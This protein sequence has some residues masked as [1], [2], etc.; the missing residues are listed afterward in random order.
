MC[1][2][3][4][5]E[6]KLL[7]EGASGDDAVPGDE[8]LSEEED[9]G[10]EVDALNAQ[11]QAGSGANAVMQQQLAACLA[12]TSVI[13]GLK[14]KIKEL[15]GKLAIRTRQLTAAEQ[16]NITLHGVEIDNAKLEE[17]VELKNEVI[18]GLKLELAT[19]RRKVVSYAKATLG[20][21]VLCVCV[22]VRVCVCVCVR[23][24]VCVWVCVCML[25]ML[26]VRSPAAAEDEAT[27]EGACGKGG[28]G[29]KGGKSGKGSKGSTKGSSSKTATAAASAS[30]AT[31]AK[32]SGR[33]SLQNCVNWACELL[34]HTPRSTLAV[35]CGTVCVCAC[36]CA[37]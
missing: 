19:L 32:K 30:V 18:K 7:Q 11:L 20:I 29:S 15:A 17:K 24:C 36:L 25:L 22:R 10:T 5:D 16:T 14:N 23:V 31:P 26:T 12:N 2:V 27:L 8:T 6:A 28:K 33:Q 1:G 35:A 34:D 37:L 4:A 13:A 3:C 21:F 9:D